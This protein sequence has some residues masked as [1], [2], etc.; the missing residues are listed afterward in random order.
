MIDVRIVGVTGGTGAGKSVLSAELEKYGAKVIDADKISRQV[1]AVG[2]SA[3]DE[4]VNCFGKEILT[5][6]GEIDRKALGSI[7]FG[8]SEKL[9]LLEKITHKHIFEEMQFQLN[10]CN[11]EVVVLDVPLLFSCDFPIKCNITIAVIADPE[12][13]LRRIMDRDG[14]TEDAALARM[15]NQLSNERYQKLADICFEN[16][17]DMEKVKRFAKNILA[18]EF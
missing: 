13:R 2:G 3:F 9:E 4:I 16:N 17:N 11:E 12:I 1:T 10:N 6:D 7:V 14:I 5:T 18:E 15:K 8:D